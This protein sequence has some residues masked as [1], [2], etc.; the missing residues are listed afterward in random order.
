MLV[1]VDP[2]HTG[3]IYQYLATLLSTVRQSVSKGVVI[4]PA[5]RGVLIVQA[6]EIVEVTSADNPETYADSVTDILLQ[7]D[8][9][10]AQ[11]ANPGSPTPSSQSA[12]TSG[13]NRSVR[14]RFGV[15]DKAI[16]IVLIRAKSGKI[17]EFVLCRGSH[18]F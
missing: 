16:E 14:S 3:L 1:L 8:G 12:G 2:S 4:D 7:V 10:N 11:L 13:S 17:N 6:L 9:E 18:G 15:I 5:Q